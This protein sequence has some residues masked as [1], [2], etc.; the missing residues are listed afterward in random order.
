[1][2]LQVFRQECEQS[3]SSC[4][5]L[6]FLVTNVNILLNESALEKNGKERSTERKRGTLR[7]KKHVRL[8]VCQTRSLLSS[9]RYLSM[10][11]R[12]KKSDWLTSRVP[13]QRDTM[14][15]ILVRVAC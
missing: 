6:S 10:N 13:L 5:S 7:E 11:S 3:R 2:I 15:Y 9:I 12:R 1:M 4:L 14:F 8:L